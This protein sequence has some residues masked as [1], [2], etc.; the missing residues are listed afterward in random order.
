ML[1]ARVQPSYLT[2]VCQ[3]GYKNCLRNGGIEMEYCAHLLHQ[4]IDSKEFVVPEEVAAREIFIN[5]PDEFT[6]RENEINLRRCKKQQFYDSQVCRHLCS[7]SL[8]RET[9]K[10][11]AF[12]PCEN[13]CFELTR[14]QNSAGQICPFEKY[15]PNGCPCEHY[16]CEKIPIEQQMVPVWELKN[17]T[18]VEG[19]VNSEKLR[20]LFYQADEIM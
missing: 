3:R 18:V 9:W 14:T 20:A 7:T 12:S 6:A 8:V 15:C 13:I 2:H 1:G 16:E 11:P 19:R 17:I 10:K 5:K 4:C